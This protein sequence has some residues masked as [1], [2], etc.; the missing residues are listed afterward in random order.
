MK[1]IKILNGNQTIAEAV[2]QI[3]P[4]VVAAYPITPSTAIVETI[5]SFKA[6]GL[7]SGEFVCPE[8]EHSAMSVCIGAAAAGGRVMTATCSQGLALMWE[9]LYIAAGLRLPIVAAI[10]NRALSAPINIHGDHSDTMGARD[11]GWIQIYSE[12]CQEAYDNFIQAFRIAEH[13]DVLTPIFVGLDG[14]IISHSSEGVQVEDD[15]AVKKFVGEFKPPYPLLDTSRKFTVGP[16][17][18][19]DYYFEHKRS[20][21]EGIENSPPVIEA[22][23]KEFGQTFGRSYGFFEKYRMD[24]AELCI[25]VMSSAAGTGKDAIDE[26]RGEGLKIGLLKPRVFRPFPHEKIAEALKNMKAVAVLDRSSAPGAFGAP[27]FT[28]IR[29]ALYD[30]ETRP[31]MINYVYG[32]GGR[33]ITVEHFTGVARRL[34]KIAAGGKVD[35]MLGYLNLRE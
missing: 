26:L 24:D 7:I 33:D 21:I 4:D 17:D 19:T 34:E 31:K 3:D 23:G 2:R 11:S 35:E 9:M 6:D 25:V 30:Y 5:A 10:A 18:F 27:L 15:Q 32:L 28:E 12:N 16:I 20:Q 22:V 29:S 14:F 13:P 8:S 1:G